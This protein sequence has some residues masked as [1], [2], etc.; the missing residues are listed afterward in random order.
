MITPLVE[1][2]ASEPSP[3]A[4]VTDTLPLTCASVIPAY[5]ITPVE[6]L[7]DI[8]P[9]PAVSD[10]DIAPLASVSV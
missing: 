5:V 1:L 2:Y 3:P 8:A 6:L 4:S 10:T 7:Y 9:S